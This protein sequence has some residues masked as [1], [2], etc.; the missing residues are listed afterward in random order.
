MDAHQVASAEDLRALI[1]ARDVEY[2]VVAL[3]DMQGL[4]RGKYLS[5]RKLLG[6]LEGGLG[7]PPVIFAMEPTD[8]LYEVVG[9]S[10]ASTGFPDVPAS[11][12]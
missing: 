7:V 10:D 4:L 3:P 1:E 8:M 11:V 12:I 2:V 6:A 9:L 5:R